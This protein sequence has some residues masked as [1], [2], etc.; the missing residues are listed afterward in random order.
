MFV[1]LLCSDL[2]GCVFDRMH[3][4]NDNCV[5][6]Y[7][8]ILVQFSPFFRRDHSFRSVTLFSFLSLDGATIFMKLQSKIAKSPKIGGKV[9]AHHFV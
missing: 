6:V 5:A 1:F 2:A 7:G 4:S 3:S 8:S 9:C